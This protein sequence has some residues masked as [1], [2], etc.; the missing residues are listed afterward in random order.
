MTVKVVT[1]GCKVNQCESGSIIAT[2]KANGYDASEGLAP[3]DVYVLNTCS[4]TAEADKKSRQYLA[5]MRGLNERC[6]IIVVGCSSQN[7]PEKFHR[8]NVVAVGGTSNKSE[9]V[10]KTIKSLANNNQYS[11][12]SDII[13]YKNTLDS[14]KNKLKYCYEL[15]PELQKTR[16]F[17]KIQDG[18]NRFCSYCIIPY[19]RGR[20][21]SRSIEDVVAECDS[22]S[23]GEIVITGIDVSSYGADIGV[24]L[25]QLLKALSK[26]TARKRLGSL[27][28]EVI[29]DDMLSAMREGNYCPHFH[30]SLQSGSTDV[31]KSMNRR[32]NSEY[33]YSKIELIRKYFPNAG[34][35]TD[36]IVGFPTETDD[37]FKESVEFIEK[38][39]F[40]DIHVFPYSSRAGTLAAKKYKVLPPEIVKERVSELLRLKANLRD[41]FF[42][43]NL[44]TVA[45]V[46]VEDQESGYNVGYTPNYIKVYSD[47]DCGDIVDLRLTDKFKDGIFG[48]KLS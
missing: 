40:S 27:E 35:T 37:L 45:S 31:L 36:V 33:F 44:N 3:A 46:Y 32:Y 41:R 16:S 12:L 22:I 4:V 47:A 19:L 1:L 5:K 20:S 13:L 21:R 6:A 2:L 24:T 43:K 28:C 14:T 38:C 30:L 9:F 29:D 8:S 15:Y 7:D 11:I 10:F 39:G 18:C 25:P 23:S 48:V 26:F 42:E 34:I 17:I